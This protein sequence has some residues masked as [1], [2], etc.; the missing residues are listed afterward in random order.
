M[1]KL[2][3]LSLL[4]IS[5]HSIKAQSTVIEGYTTDSTKGFAVIEIVLNDTLSKIMNNPKEGRPKY[6][7]MYQNPKY[8]VRTDSTGK[9]RIKAAL[10][11]SLYFK[12][13]QHRTKVYSV[14]DLSLQK[15]IRI[16]LERE[17]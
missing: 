4:F 6:L 14:K 7:K 2:F 15:D 5:A 16:V 10:S 17:K 9:F 1:R 12:S 13:Y 3:L 11:D 8:V